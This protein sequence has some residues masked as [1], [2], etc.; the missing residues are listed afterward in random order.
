MVN[1]NQHNVICCHLNIYGTNKR[2]CAYCCFAKVR[3][4]DIL[5][6]IC[7]K[8]SSFFIGVQKDRRRDCIITGKTIEYDCLYETA[9]AIYIIEWTNHP[10]KDSRAEYYVS[11][12][13]S[14]QLFPHDNY[15]SIKPVFLLVLDST[16]KS[17]STLISGNWDSKLGD[18]RRYKKTVNLNYSDCL[19]KKEID[20]KV[21]SSIL[22]FVKI[23]QNP[24][25][26]LSKEDK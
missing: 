10:F 18:G 13:M 5:S 9:D 14:D 22:K 25:V 6:W 15:D 4:K 2:L 11:C 12:G 1:K 17:D 26:I 8:D 19:D 16:K 24:S 20:L 23:I 7:D 3:P 21:N